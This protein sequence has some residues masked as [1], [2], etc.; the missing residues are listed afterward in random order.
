MLLVVY[1]LTLKMYSSFE[2]TALKLYPHAPFLF[3]FN[4]QRLEHALKS[5]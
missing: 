1:Y 5:L 4:D 3:I 2:V